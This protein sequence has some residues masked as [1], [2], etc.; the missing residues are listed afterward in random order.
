MSIRERNYGLDLLRIVSMFMILILHFLG[1]N[2]IL[3]N[4]SFYSFNNHLAWLLES[5][6]IV[7]VNCYVLISGY[8]S[9]DSKFNSKRIIDIWLKVLFYSILIGCFMF[10]FCN[11]PL[12]IINIINC[13]F[14]V[15]TKTYW[16]ITVYICLCF[17]S[18]FLNILIKNLT[19]E[20]YRLLIILCFILF[21]L[22]PTFVP[23]EFM[24]DLNGGTGIVWFCFLYLFAAYIRLYGKNIKKRKNY[25]IFYLISCLI[26]FLAREFI[27]YLFPKIGLNA[28]FF[29]KLYNYNTIFVFI[30]SLCLFYYFNNLFIKKQKTKDLIKCIAPYTLAVYL[31]HEHPLFISTLY[32]NIF[33]INELINSNYIFLVIILDAV[34]LYIF[35]ILIDK[36]RN[37]IMLFFNNLK[38]ILKFKN[39]LSNFIKKLSIIINKFFDYV[40]G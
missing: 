12:S 34:L 7:A 15:F 31:I 39:M 1:K 11:T 22:I 3:T 14:P 13:F 36:A 26:L 19:K 28:L 2:N 20:K 37:K 32:N 5:L 8:F 40:I 24:I 38:I 4:S 35:C 30:S 23:S 10:M 33:H 9:I 27:L 21:C 16:F 6:C 25:L 18:P 17:F 29:E